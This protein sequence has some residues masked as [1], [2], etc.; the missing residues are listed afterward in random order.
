VAVAIATAK[1]I[2]IL[3]YFM[4]IRYSRPLTWAV[5]G[6]AFFWLFIL[7]GLTLS[8]YLTRKL[9]NAPTANVAGEHIAARMQ[10]QPAAKD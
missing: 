6:A 1:A 8:D 3:L 2:L 4:H 9:P 7:F 5:A 10:A